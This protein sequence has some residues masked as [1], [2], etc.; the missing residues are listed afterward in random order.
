MSVGNILPDL[1]GLVHSYLGDG[2]IDSGEENLLRSYREHL[3][4]KIEPFI[5]EYYPD[6]DCTEAPSGGYDLSKARIV[7]FLTRFAI[8]YTPSDFQVFQN[9]HSL[10]MKTVKGGC[11]FIEHS[12]GTEMQ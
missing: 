2:E 8:D 6:K 4:R 3:A 9:A 1:Y 10:A 7:P 12:P 11:A 5:N